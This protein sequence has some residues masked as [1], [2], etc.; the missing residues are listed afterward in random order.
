MTDD[1]KILNDI[2]FWLNYHKDVNVFYIR[3]R[4][5][6][7]KWSIEKINEA[8]KYIQEQ[9][10]EKDLFT[11]PNRNGRQYKVDTMI[12]T[13]REW[14]SRNGWSMDS[15]KDVNYFCQREKNAR[16]NNRRVNYE[17]YVIDPQSMF[18]DYINLLG[19]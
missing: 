1:D 13:V 3:Q 5:K 12:D 11:F 2:E 8:V 4:I 15:D 16:K 17:H 6:L 14:A 7:E 18:I 9:I 10:M 19:R